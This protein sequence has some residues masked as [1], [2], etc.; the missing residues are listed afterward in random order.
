MSDASR[1]VAIV[2]GASSGIGA[3]VAARLQGDGYTVFGT[4]RNVAEPRSRT[5]GITM[6]ALDVRDDKAVHVLI[7]DVMRA[8]G[9]ID[10]LVN[11][12]GSQL[13]GAAE[14]T[15]LDEARALFDVNFFGVVRV[16]T[17]VLPHM[18]AAQRGRI[19]F[20]GSVLGF[21][22]APFMGIYSASKHALEGYAE[23]LDHEVRPFGIRSILIEPSFTATR[24][25][26]NQGEAS[27]RLPAYAA[28]RARMLQ[29]F[30]EETERGGSPESVAAAVLEAATAPR[31][32]L[33]YRVGQARSLSRL[34]RF[35]PERLFDKS[36]RGRFPLDA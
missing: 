9:R 4:S 28:V 7:E 33:R 29:K 19:I 18:R 25:V 27:Q 11:N 5:D 12:A 24:L 36:F 6:R 15:S 17:A 16:T 32:K 30:A 34:R 21:L 10:V 3:A 20:I 35:I 31:P 1:K 8:A 22:P 13:V 2:T 23:S 14:E 26:K